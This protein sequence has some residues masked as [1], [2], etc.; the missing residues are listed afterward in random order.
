[1]G[2]GSSFA[3]TT[4]NITTNNNNNNSD[5]TAHPGRSLSASS[6]ISREPKALASTFTSAIAVSKG[7]GRAGNLI[8]IVY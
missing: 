1:M 3:T 5:Q 2:G 7:D 6:C 8:Q 4:N